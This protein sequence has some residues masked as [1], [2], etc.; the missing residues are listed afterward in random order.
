MFRSFF[1]DILYP[2]RF[3]RVSPGLGVS[4]C[5]PARVRRGWHPGWM[6]NVW[7]T[8]WR[9]AGGDYIDLDA[10]YKWIFIKIRV[11]LESVGVLFAPSSEW[12]QMLDHTSFFFATNIDKL[13]TQTNRRSPWTDSY[14]EYDMYYRLVLKLLIFMTQKM[15]SY[16][17]LFWHI[18]D[19]TCDAMHIGQRSWRSG[20]PPLRNIWTA[21]AVQRHLVKL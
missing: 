8:Q 15:F 7:G 6:V 9:S 13:Y 20:I 19:L 17:C 16:F 3:R 21:P 10:I 5:R 11:W 18:G 12:T 1:N 2:V 14:F 4:V